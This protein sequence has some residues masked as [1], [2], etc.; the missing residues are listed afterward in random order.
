MLSSQL[1]PI[2]QIADLRRTHGQTILAEAW[3]GQSPQR[4]DHNGVVYSV[5]LELM[6]PTALVEV[7]LADHAVIR[8]NDQKIA[9]ASDGESSYGLVEFPQPS[10][11]NY[12]ARI[13]EAYRALLEGCSQHGTPNLI[14]VWHYLPNIHHQFDGLDHYQH[15]CAARYRPLY[16]HCVQSNQGFPAATVI[17]NQSNS[18]VIAFIA[19]AQP[20]QQFENPRQVSA[21]DYP[22]DYGPQSPSFARASGLGQGDD[23]QL[24]ISGTASI[25]GHQTQHPD[26]VGAQAEEVLQNLDNLIQHC[27]QNSDFDRK[28]IQQARVYLRNAEDKARLEK[29]LATSLSQTSPLLWLQADLCRRELAIEIEAIA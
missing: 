11:D 12:D 13:A 16:T 25:V 9:W 15:F 28:A 17:G 29:M 27:Q 23:F 2:D 3:H 5:P 8:V 21:Y 18:L 4:A 1:I 24:Y 20:V 6:Q 22:S 10:S 7:W 19:S 26:D 14:R